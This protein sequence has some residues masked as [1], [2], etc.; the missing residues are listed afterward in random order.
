[1]CLDEETLSK[2]V[3]RVRRLRSA[4]LSSAATEPMYLVLYR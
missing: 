4:D 3:V 2:L 1:M